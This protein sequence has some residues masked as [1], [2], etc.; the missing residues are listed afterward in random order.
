MGGTPRRTPSPG[1]RRHSDALHRLW[2]ERG[3]TTSEYV[4]LL[5]GF[6]TAAV[7]AIKLVVVGVG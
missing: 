4:V 6:V 3:A 1:R 5:L 2:S 7:L